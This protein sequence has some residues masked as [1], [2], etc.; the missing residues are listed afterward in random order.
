[1]WDG[2]LGEF[3]ACLNVK[4][5][6]E[7]GTTVGLFRWKQPAR[8]GLAYRYHPA[9]QRRG[10]RGDIGVVGGDGHGTSGQQRVIARAVVLTWQDE[11][12]P[13]WV[14]LLIGWPMLRPAACIVKISC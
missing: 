3:L 6:S 2:L 11:L 5:G 1:V 13:V 10:R 12:C 9:G 14:R 4:T 7:L 8:V